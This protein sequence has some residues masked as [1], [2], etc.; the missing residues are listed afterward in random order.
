MAPAKRQSRKG[1][2]PV[3]AAKAV[4]P[5]IKKIKGGHHNKAAN[6]ARYRAAQA[7]VLAM[8]KAGKPEPKRQNGGSTILVVQGDKPR[9]TIYDEELARAI[10]LKFATDP[11]M[12]LN[13]LNADPLMPTVW[14]FYEWRDTHADLDKVYTRSRE[15]QFD[16]QAERLRTVSA[17]PLK[18]VITVERTGG[19]DGDTFETRTV[20]NV[21]RA[22]LIVE[23]DKWLLSKLRPKKYGLQADAVPTGPNEQ[24]EGLFAALKAGP[25][26]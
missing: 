8:K 11:D 26:K 20:D 6:S 18:G 3:P 4:V 7:E 1:A 9:P 17:N 19:K 15:L 16:L 25:K 14:T 10:C 12:S 23:T 13:S 5:V 21:E 24:L 2:P 22:R